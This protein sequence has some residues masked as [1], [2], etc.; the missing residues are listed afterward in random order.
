M[1][2]KTDKPKHEF[3]PHKGGPIESRFHE[4]MVDAMRSLDLSF[5]G[6]I[7]GPGRTVGLVL[8]VFPY[9]E[10]DREGPEHRCNYIS[11][12]ADRREMITLLREQAQHFEDHL[13]ETEAKG[14]TK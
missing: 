4:A 6:K 3:G 13:K 2:K 8:L 11:N 9:G 5:N 14:K 10:E 1:P 12:G 7:G